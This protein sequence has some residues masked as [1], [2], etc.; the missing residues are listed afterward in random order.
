MHL[1]ERELEFHTETEEETRVI[2]EAFSLG[3]Q[4]D[5]KVMMVGGFLRDYKATITCI[6]RECLNV[7]TSDGKESKYPS[8]T[9]LFTVVLD[10]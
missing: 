7:Q 10:G 3:N 6:R 9:I 2:E 4:I 5:V 8:K 1:M